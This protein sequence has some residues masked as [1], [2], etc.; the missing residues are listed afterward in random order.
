MRRYSSYDFELGRKD[1]ISNFI[2]FLDQNNVFSLIVASVLASRVSEMANALVTHLL[3]PILERDGD[4]DGTKDIG[5]VEQLE[6]NLMGCRF[7]YGIVLVSIIKMLFVAYIVY[8]VTNFL[9]SRK[10]VV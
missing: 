9:Q 10:G 4:Q 8:R 1:E 3:M 2:D 5:M 7:K 6:A